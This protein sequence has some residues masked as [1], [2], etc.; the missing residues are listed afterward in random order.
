MATGESRNKLTVR[1]RRGTGRRMTAPHIPIL[2]RGLPYESLDTSPVVDHRNGDVLAE[3][4]MANPG[5]IRKDLRQFS[6]SFAQLQAMSQ[7]DL[8]DICIAAGEQFLHGNLTQSPEEYVRVLSAT[9]GLP[10]TLCHA[11]MQ[12][13]YSVMANMPTILGGLTRNLDL[14][15]LDSLCA[16][17][18]SYFPTT[19]A[20]AAVLPSNSPGVNSLYLPAIALK[21]PLVL[22]PG[23]EEP[24]TPYRVIESFVAAG[25]PREAF[26]YYPTSHAGSAEI[27]DM[28]GRCILFGD[29]KIADKYAGNRSVSVH[30]PGYSKIVIGEDQ[31]DRWEDH[32]DVLVDSVAANSGRSCINCSTILVPRHGRAI[33]EALASRLDAMEPLPLNDPK[34]RLSAMANSKMAAGINAMISSRLDTPGAAEMTRGSDD[35][36]VEVGGSTFLRPTLI[37][38]DDADH[39]LAR[40]E[41]M[42]PF[43]SVVELPRKQ[44]IDYI[45]PSLVLSAITDDPTLRQELLAC[46]HIDRLN[47][48]RLPTTKVEWNQP[49][50]GN[51]FEFLYQRRAIQ[52]AG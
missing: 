31:I 14:S 34:A 39:P 1:A 22:K 5:L 23:R 46:P 4:S 30:G 33:A 9:S 35:R 10:E 43:C 40:T 28:V 24:W 12:K 3:L 11:N 36:L 52:V 27:I 44:W 29:K 50:E 45:G 25:A 47:L 41:F 38:C 6:Q 21:I 13:V 49:H 32:L 7:R 18:L 26:G 37:H 20:L 19:H 16:D 2:R 42:F 48:G 51:L 8:M 15:I 17:G